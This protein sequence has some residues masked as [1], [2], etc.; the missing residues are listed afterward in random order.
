MG[1]HLEG[2]GDSFF[3]FL[4]LLRFCVSPFCIDLEETLDCEIPLL[5]SENNGRTFYDGL[6][7]KLVIERAMFLSGI[8]METRWWY[9]CFSVDHLWLSLDSSSCSLSA[10]WKSEC[11]CLSSTKLG[12]SSV[13][14]REHL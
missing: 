13:P 10:R 1:M 3:F 4:C 2:V 9:L 6:I 12:G 14:H 8:R 11:S 5:Q 7:Q